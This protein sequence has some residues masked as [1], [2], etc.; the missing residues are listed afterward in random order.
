MGMGASLPSLHAL[1]VHGPGD[2]GEEIGWRKGGEM[3][4]G[5]SLTSPSPGPGGRPMPCCVSPMSVLLRKSPGE[6][7]PF[8]SPLSTVQSEP[9]FA[10]YF[11]SP[12]PL[13]SAPCP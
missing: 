9:H 12:L 8:L 4:K 10:K 11:P 1:C 3:P 6:V 5:T 7:S 2:A 13:L